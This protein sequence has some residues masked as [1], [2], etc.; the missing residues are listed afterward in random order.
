MKTK[1]VNNIRKK[2]N[3]S[4]HSLNSND[5]KQTPKPVPRKVNQSNRKESD[6]DDDDDEF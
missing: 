1:K 4:N 2:S 5:S 3:E 6:D